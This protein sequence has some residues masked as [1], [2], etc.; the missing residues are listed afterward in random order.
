MLHS[1][2]P[3]VIIKAKNE[4][5]QISR[6]AQRTVLL[7]PNPPP[8]FRTPRRGANLPPA[9]IPSTHRRR[10]MIYKK[11]IELALPKDT[12]LDMLTMQIR[13]TIPRGYVREPTFRLYK[14][15]MHS[16]NRTRFEYVITGTVKICAGN[17]IINCTIRPT[18]LT[19]VLLCIIFYIF[20][21]GVVYA[22]K[23]GK[24][25]VFL[26]ISMVACIIAV[27]AVIWQERQCY[28]RFERCFETRGQGDGSVVP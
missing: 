18:I 11:R 28:E 20:I 25:E 8:H 21:E 13:S 15:A 1:S 9:R 17:T 14:T 19:C 24:N 3:A 27:L 2:I 12:V 10:I 22:I 5:H 7:S 23:G 26:L 6:L 16:G 4:K